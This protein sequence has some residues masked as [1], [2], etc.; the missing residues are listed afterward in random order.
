MS[1]RIGSVTKQFTAA[2]ILWL[3]EQGKLSVADDLTKFLPDFP[4]GGRHVTIEQLLTHTSGIRNFTAAPTWQ[5]LK[6][7][8]LTTAEMVAF[9]GELGF[10]FAPGE[11]WSYSNSG[12]FLLGA[13]IEK[14]SGLSYAAFLDQHVF[15][16]LGL[17]RTYYDNPSTVIPRRARGYQRGSDAYVNAPYISMTQPF[18]AGALASTVDDLL[19]WDQSLTTGKLLKP[20]GIRRMFTPHTLESGTKTTYGY[21]W[22]LAQHAGHAIAEHGGGIEGFRSHVVRIP[23]ERLFVAVLTNNGSAKPD[24]TLL[25]R[26][27]AAV[28]LGQPLTGNSWETRDTTTK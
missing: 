25:A 5:P 15:S 26:R 21:G 22:A 8:D 27:I 20:D 10:Q 3:E 6:M 17:R 12:Y 16:P 23:S 9:I 4:V 18:A 19:Q 13:I 1:F 2:A 11:R 7:R 14:A 24:P 28:A